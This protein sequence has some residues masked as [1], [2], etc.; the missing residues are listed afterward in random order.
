MEAVLL[1]L[2]HVVSLFNEA[3]DTSPLVKILKY[4]TSCMHTT[5]Q[6]LHSLCGLLI[7]KH[8][9][10]QKNNIFQIDHEV[11]RMSLIIIY[12]ATCLDNLPSPG[13]FY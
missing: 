10:Q 8:A 11:L 1:T 7:H 12:I 2:L 6:Q 3:C 9:L 13:N 4:K 5:S